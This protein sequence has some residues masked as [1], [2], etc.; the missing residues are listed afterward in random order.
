MNSTTFVLDGQLSPR[1]D[2]GE[3]DDPATRRPTSLHI[4]KKESPR[5][6]DTQRH[7]VESDPH[8]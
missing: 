5:D 8:R 4:E 3:Q 7:R 6:E 1:P 2:S